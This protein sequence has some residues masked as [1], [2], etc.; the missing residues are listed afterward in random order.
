MLQ[1]A[2]RNRSQW[3]VNVAWIRG[4]RKWVISWWRCW[5]CF[6]SFEELFHSSLF[7]HFLWRPESVHL[8][9]NVSVFVVAGLFSRFLIG[10]FSLLDVAFQW[11]RE[12]S[13]VTFEW[14]TRRFLYLN[15]WSYKFQMFFEGKIDTYVWHFN[16]LRL[17]YEIQKMS[18]NTMGT[19]W[20][21]KLAQISG[22]IGEKEKNSRLSLL[23]I[24]FGPGHKTLDNWVIV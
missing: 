24:F 11:S 5:R 23:F 4:S 20:Q 18:T 2:N 13:Y 19:F 9:L 3:F 10:N 17:F 12:I 21:L 15:Q 22:C 16:R 8:R 1:L 7:L 14:S 6:L